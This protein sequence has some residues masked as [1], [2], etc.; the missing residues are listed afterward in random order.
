M[1]S[2]EDETL[3]IDSI[4]K[5]KT[6]IQDQLSETEK[7]KS[8]LEDIQL[9]MYKLDSQL[10]SKNKI[11]LSSRVLSQIQSSMDGMI[12]IQDVDPKFY[13]H[14]KRMKTPFS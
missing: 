7:K 11:Q 6:I 2:E 10:K 13:F 8:S 5:L 14:R 9:T 3:H 4:E 1:K 12:Q